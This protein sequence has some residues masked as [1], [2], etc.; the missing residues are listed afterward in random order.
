MVYLKFDPGLL[1]S[2]AA[3]VMDVLI[4]LFLWNTCENFMC[5]CRNAIAG[6]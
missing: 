6:S 3:I 1:T 2:K 5:V 4:Y